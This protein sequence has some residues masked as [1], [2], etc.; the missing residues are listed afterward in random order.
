[1]IRNQPPWNPRVR[2]FRRK[3]KRA[4]HFVG[5]IFRIVKN[6]IKKQVKFTAKIIHRI[7]FGVILHVCQ[8]II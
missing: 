5:G 4:Y 2:D 6:K 8:F 1:M 3:R 7:E